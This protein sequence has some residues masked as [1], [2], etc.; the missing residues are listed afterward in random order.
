[1]TARQF[2]RDPSH[3][4][5]NFV[6]IEWRGRGDTSFC[7]AL[8]TR[9][10]C[11]D[12]LR[13]REHHFLV[14]GHPSAALCCAHPTPCSLLQVTDLSALVVISL[15]QQSENMQL[16]YEYCTLAPGT[17]DIEFSGGN[18]D[19]LLDIFK[20]LIQDLV[21]STLRNKFPDIFQGVLGTLNAVLL[22]VRQWWAV[23][24]RSH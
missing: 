3:H 21:T 6:A 24:P 15:N 2:L 22:K 18:L 19:W 4:T 12:V 9:T 5:H 20:P 17:F 1:M 11:S 8:A 23:S 16:G 14:G 10:H 13:L 7:L